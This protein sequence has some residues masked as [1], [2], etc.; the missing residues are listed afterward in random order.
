MKQ[1]PASFLFH[2]YET[3]GIS[4]QYDYPCQF[5]AIRTDQNLEPIAAPINITATIH[6]DYLPHPQA[7]LVTGITP[8]MTITNGQNEYEF[9]RQVHHAMMQP[10]TCVVGYNS[11][12]FDI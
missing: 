1:L 8:Q 12:K 9:M 7:V 5:A 10:N 11:I 6:L 3:W 2:D 4:P